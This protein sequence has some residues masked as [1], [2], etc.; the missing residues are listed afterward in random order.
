MYPTQFGWLNHDLQ[1]LIIRSKVL[2]MALPWSWLVMGNREQSYDPSGTS[3]R[4]CAQVSLRGLSSFRCQ[5][6]ARLKSWCRTSLLTIVSSAQ[7]HIRWTAATQMQW[8]YGKLHAKSVQF[9]GLLRPW[10]C[11]TTRSLTK[12]SDGSDDGWE[13]KGPATLCG[14]WPDR[15]RYGDSHC[16]PTKNNLYFHG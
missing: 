8:Y 9:E 7:K 3:H 6:S 13:K 5:I 10:V 15:L 1:S 14:Q 16:Q 11:L 12:P 4:R 2:L